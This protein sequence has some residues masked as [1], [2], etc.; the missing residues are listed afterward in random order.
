MCMMLEAFLI[1][2]GS[3][4][5]GPCVI[6]KE[7]RAMGGSQP[8]L[9]SAS[10]AGLTRLCARSSHSTPITKVPFCRNSNYSP[11]SE[12][13]CEKCKHFV[14]LRKTSHKCESLLRK[15]SKKASPATISSSEHMGHVQQ[16]NAEDSVQLDSTRQSARSLTTVL[17]I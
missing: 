15:K 5:Q 16:G 14:D 1:T 11:S 3:W 17:S 12:H 4:R 10:R 13:G 6:P 7:R 8:A 9:R 2:G